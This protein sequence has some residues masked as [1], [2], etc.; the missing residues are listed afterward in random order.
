MARILCVKTVFIGSRVLGCVRSS[1]NLMGQDVFLLLVSRFWTYIQATVR[2]PCLTYKNEEKHTCFTQAGTGLHPKR[3]KANFR[4]KDTCPS[5]QTQSRDG[6]GLLSVW[7][8]HFQVQK[9][10]NSVKRFGEIPGGNGAALVELQ[11]VNISAQIL[12]AS[13]DR[14]TVLSIQHE[15]RAMGQENHRMVLMPGE[16]WDPRGKLEPAM[17]PRGGSRQHTSGEGWWVPRTSWEGSWATWSC[18]RHRTSMRLPSLIWK[19]M[20]PFL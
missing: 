2:S 3:D 16:A 8:K 17:P 19:I 6:Q 1:L 15:A 5:P 9:W 12:W 7:Q 4:K 18:A 13:W 11:G 10:R 20:T 14:Q